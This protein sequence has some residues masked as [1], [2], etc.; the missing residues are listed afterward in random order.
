M[1]KRLCRCGLE[2]G[3][4]TEVHTSLAPRVGLQ[5]C[6]KYRMVE[7]VPF[8]S[9]DPRKEAI[10]RLAGRIAGHMAEV[11][12]HK[13]AL[14]IPVQRHAR[15]MAEAM[16]KDGVHYDTAILDEI[17]NNPE[18]MKKIEGMFLRHLASI[19]AI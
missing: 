17:T 2:R 1:Y 7:I 18:T 3:G 12:Y 9:R 14:D 10:D 13:E 8:P 5:P 6:H 15:L 16:L 11:L 4:P 19:G